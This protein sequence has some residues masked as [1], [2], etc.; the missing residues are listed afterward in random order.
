MASPAEQ[1]ADIVVGRGVIDGSS[2]WV[3][4]IGKLPSE[5]DKVAV[6]YDTGGP[7]PN[8]KW[9]LDYLSVQCIV[10]GPPNSYNLGWTKIREVRDC[11]LGLE[12]VTLGSGDRIDGV[13]ILSDIT[14][15]N[16][17]DAQRPTF[18]VNFRIFY[19]PA[20]N[21]LTQREPL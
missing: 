11:L 12:P 19:E 4:K 20:S 9:L 16:Y 15:I 18:S 2:G 1:L 14:F 21:G 7:S 6:F 17:D 13:I 8:P 5:P 3:S 10:R